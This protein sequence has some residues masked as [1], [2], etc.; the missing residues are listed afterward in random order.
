MGN[1]PDAHETLIGA[2]DCI[3][4]A[5]DTPFGGNLSHGPDTGIIYRLQ[6][7][8]ER[9]IHGKLPRKRFILDK[10]EIQFISGLDDRLR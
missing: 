2:F 7:C 5:A 3:Q 8:L 6:I 4:L 10:E 9:L 1:K